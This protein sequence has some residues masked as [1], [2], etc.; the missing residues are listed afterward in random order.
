MLKLVL[1]VVCLNACIGWNYFKI[2]NNKYQ[3]PKYENYYAEDLQ[4]LLFSDEV[5]WFEA[6]FICQAFNGHLAE[7]NTV[8]KLAKNSDRLEDAVLDPHQ[9]WIG[10]FM[11]SNYT[12][13]WIKS[14]LPI[15]KELLKFAN[16]FRKPVNIYKQCLAI[17]RRYNNI[18][19]INLRCESR[20]PF[21]C[22]M[23]IDDRVQ[24]PGM[25]THHSILIENKTF[26]LYYEKMT[27]IRAV[28]YCRLMGLQLAILS[29]EN[30]INRIAHAMLQ[31]RPSLK[32]IWISGYFDRTWKWLPN[33]KPFQWNVHDRLN[34]QKF[35]FSTFNECITLNRH[36]NY[37]EH[38]F[39][40][41]K[42]ITPKAFLCETVLETTPVLNGTTMTINKFNFSLIM[43][44]SSWI[45][46]Q[47]HCRM[48]DGNLAELIQDG[49]VNDLSTF[50]ENQPEEVERIWL[51]GIYK[52]Y[53]W[54]WAK[55]KK[56]IE[57]D[58]INFYDANYGSE[59]LCLNLDIAEMKMYGLNCAFKQFF[60][61]I[62]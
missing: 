24:L 53:K 30:E 47:R 56:I 15:N 54:I 52:N 50:L 48:N 60:V 21:L 55:S 19:L 44:D 2:K 11:Y 46:A 17:D 28:G 27:W 43:K 49:D 20:K 33:L 9:I 16:W 36:Y 40:P 31:G 45:Q 42:C 41:T 18:V 8:T 51:G 32:E 6:L 26:V 29:N 61:C 39:I 10:G 57:T 37:D 5:V 14:S 3:L 13:K 35:N 58:R 4:Y 1:I 62:A 12:W 7:L 59:S 22:E 23:T 38:A 34:Y 25:E